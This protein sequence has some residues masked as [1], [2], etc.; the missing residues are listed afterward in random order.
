MY[1]YDAGAFAPLASVMRDLNVHEDKIQNVIRALNAGE[2]DLS[3]NSF[4]EAR[5][6]EGSFGGSPIG[7]DLGSHH[8]RAQQV[9]TGTIQGVTDDLVRFRDGVRQAVQLVNTADQSS[10]DDLHRKREVAESL[11]AV[12]QNSSGDRAYDDA[13]NNQSPTDSTGQPTPSGGDA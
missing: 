3:D 12:W 6:S 11:Q 9:F 4:A 1:M 13:R 10:A 8:S 2:N 5:I 7:H